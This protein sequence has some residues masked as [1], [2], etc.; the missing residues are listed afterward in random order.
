MQE[1]VGGLASSF[2]SKAKESYAILWIAWALREKDVGS[3]GAD[4]ATEER[5]RVRWSSN[6]PRGPTEEMN[7]LWQRETGSQYYAPCSS[8]LHSFPT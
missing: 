5:A 2:G 3:C 4:L 7:K 1:Q 8:Y 6:C